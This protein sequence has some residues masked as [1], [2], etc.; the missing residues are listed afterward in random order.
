[1]KIIF[2][3]TP[4][5]VLPIL[6]TLFA[7]Y[8]RTVDKGLIGV[9]TQPPKPAG[10][11]QRMSYSPVDEW[12][13]KHKLSIYT[14]LD[15]VPEADL[16]VVAAYGKII[17]QQ[18]IEKFKYGILNIHPSLLP[19]Y[20]GA[21]PIQAAILAGDE[22]TGVTIIKMDKE[23]DHGPILS[24][25]KERVNKNDTTETL[26]TRLFNR[27]AQFLLDLIP[28]YVDRKI[29][30]KPQN[31]DEATF[32]KTI[33]KKD[34]YV[35]LSGDAA[36]TERKIRAMYPW[37]GA[38]TEIYLSKDDK[39]PKQLK[40]LEAHVE[41]NKLVLDKVQLEGKNPVTWKQFTEGYPDFVFKK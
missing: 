22:M 28:N 12:A 13:Y 29:M 36:E 21:S 2:F 38:W 31:H 10:R 23:M 6:E 8:N 19:K 34:G 16:G 41:D 39:L 3:G 27:S 35:S 1:M 30:P 32:T 14:N 4:E 20:R 26:R 18:I 40:I 11:G 25:F 5:F 15:E 17:P 9:V 33:I 7:K 24:S 37:P